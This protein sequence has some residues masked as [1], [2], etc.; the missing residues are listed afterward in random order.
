ML[1]PSTESCEMSIASKAVNAQL[2][3][4]VRNRRKELLKEEPEP[5]AYVELV[6]EP[7]EAQADFGTIH[8]VRDSKIVEARALILSFPWSNRRLCGSNAI[9]E[10]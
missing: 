7:G 2:G 4:M 10:R 9:R 5:T 3:S 6:H 1:Q 8:C